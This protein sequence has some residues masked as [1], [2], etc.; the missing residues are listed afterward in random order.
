MNIK[1]LSNHVFIELET[2]E[3]MTK[4]GIYIPETADKER[5]VKGKILAIG[6]GKRNEDGEMIPM[7]VK[8]GDQVLFRKYGPDEIEVEG[9]KYL[10]GS[11]DDI[12]AVI[13]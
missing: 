6:P 7:S 13:E 4:S 12:L 2:Q 8:I 9:K 5:P 1:P 10:F 11:E 3:T